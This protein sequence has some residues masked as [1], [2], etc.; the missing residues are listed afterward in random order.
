MLVHDDNAGRGAAAKTRAPFE[1]YLPFDVEP[2]LDGTAKEATERINMY[3]TD[4]SAV[5]RA[6][7]DNHVAFWTNYGSSPDHVFSLT[8]NVPVKR[9]R[10]KAIYPM[11]WVVPKEGRA[12]RAL[13]WDPPRR[14]QAGGLYVP[15]RV[16]PIARAQ[17]HLRAA[18]AA[19]G[20]RHGRGAR[21]DPAEAAPPVQRMRRPTRVPGRE[22]ATTWARSITSS[23]YTRA[24]G[25]ASTTC[26]SCAATA[27]WRR[28]SASGP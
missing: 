19:T 5:Q 14:L 20:R 4:A 27:T 17:G 26:R 22:P 24:A 11:V 2:F 9:N 25:E 18:E 8:I 13:V 1:C 16:P 6:L 15:R 23:P 12:L 21:G 10:R 7:R 3:T 28:R